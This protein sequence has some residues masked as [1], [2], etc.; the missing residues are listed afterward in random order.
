MAK[1]TITALVLF[2]IG[3]PALIFGGIL[4][5]IVIGFFVTVAAWEYASMFSTLRSRKAHLLTAGSTLV[6]FTSRY[7]L[8]QDKAIIILGALILLSVAV[9]LFEYER[10]HDQ[11]SASL[12]ATISGIVYIGWVGS[13]LADLRNLPNGG[14]WIMLVLPSVWLTDTGAYMIGVKYGKHKMTPRLSPKKSWE[15]LIAGIVSAVA[16]SAYFAWAYS[17]YGPLSNMTPIKGAFLGLLISVLTPLGDLAESMFKREAGVK[18]SGNILPGH[19]GAFDRIDSWIWAAI[20]GY[21]F[22]IWVGI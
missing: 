12:A 5:Y 4:Y 15:G 20:I 11:V 17:T 14:W 9:H 13:Y 2:A 10:G 21:Y 1:R 18:D 8:G 6:I 16:G 7:Y 22:I 19:G 3:L